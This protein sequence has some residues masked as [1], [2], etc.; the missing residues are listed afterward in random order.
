MRYDLPKSANVGGV[1]YEIRYDFR[2]VLDIFEILND[3]EFKEGQRTLA[4]MPIFYVDF[5]SIPV[6]DWKEA[7][8]KMYWFLNGGEDERQSDKKPARLLDWEQDFPIIIAPVNRILG[9]ETRL[10]DYD[11]GE[12]TGGVHWWTFLSAYMEIGDCLFSQ[13][14]SI[15]D[16][17]AKGKRLDKFEQEFYNRNKDL[18]SLKGHYSKADDDFIKE[19][20]G[21]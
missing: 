16:K 8:E 10:V 15:R 2:P 7:S 21:R 6:S 13:I 4:A 14:V 9:Y 18:I 3:P 12:N 19:W 20:T 17:K 11:E 5:D 1:E